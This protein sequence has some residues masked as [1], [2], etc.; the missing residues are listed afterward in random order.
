SKVITAIHELVAAGAVTK[1][2]DPTSGKVLHYI[3]S[4]LAPPVTNSDRLDVEPVAIGD[5]SADNL[6]TVATPP[7]ANSDTP[8]RPQR[9]L[10]VAIGDTERESE[11]QESKNESQEPTAGGSA[12]RKVPPRGRRKSPAQPRKRDELFDALAEVT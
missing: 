4:P 8:C 3:L 5:R 6:S 1:I 10:P 12:A 9:H 2:G 7:V 11:E